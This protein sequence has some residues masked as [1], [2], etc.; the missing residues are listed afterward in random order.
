MKK[1]II[2]ISSKNGLKISVPID[3]IDSI[4]ET[5]EGTRVYL[6]SNS[7]EWFAVT[8]SATEITKRINQIQNRYETEDI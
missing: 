7:S 1:F 3:N 2:L 5:T 6:L 4:T 8:E